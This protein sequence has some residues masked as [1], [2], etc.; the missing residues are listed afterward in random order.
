MSNIT[1]LVKTSGVKSAS[2]RGGDCR[3]SSHGDSM[4]DM[5]NCGLDVGSGAMNSGAAVCV[6]SMSASGDH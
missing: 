4:G 5:K 2:P 3:K 6:F 1:G